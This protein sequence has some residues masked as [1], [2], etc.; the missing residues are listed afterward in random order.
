MLGLML[1]VITKDLPTHFISPTPNT[2]T[3]APHVIFI[4]KRIAACSI[5]I[6]SFVFVEID[7]SDTN[8]KTTSNYDFLC[9]F[10][11]TMLFYTGMGLPFASCP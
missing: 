2:A 8:S 5:R 1:P 3:K 6:S 4:I 7:S 11:G 9:T 10:Y